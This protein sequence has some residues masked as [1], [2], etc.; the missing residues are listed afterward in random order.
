M[1]VEV[2]IPGGPDCTDC[3]FLQEIVDS[4]GMEESH[5]WCSYLQVKLNKAV[6]ITDKPVKK[7]K[8]CPVRLL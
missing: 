5:N 1:K 6:S 7:H 2:E 4:W 3:P 8:R